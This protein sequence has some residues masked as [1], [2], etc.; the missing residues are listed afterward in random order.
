[1]S[2][3]IVG[4]STFKNLPVNALQGQFLLLHNIFLNLW[5]Q[6]IFIGVGFVLTLHFVV[7]IQWRSQKNIFTEE[8]VNYMYRQAG[9]W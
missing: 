8:K 1:M 3:K 9:I 5:Y 4:I 6:I 2:S 7:I